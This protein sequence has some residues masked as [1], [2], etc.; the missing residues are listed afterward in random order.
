MHTEVHSKDGCPWCEK[1]K[2]WLSERGHTY[3]EVRHDDPD[4]RASF[5]NSL[6][7]EGTERTMPQVFIVEDGESIR[8]GGYDKLEA[9]GL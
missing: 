7:L 3:T 5:Y 6:N 2:A 1:A 9:S 8:V 4:E